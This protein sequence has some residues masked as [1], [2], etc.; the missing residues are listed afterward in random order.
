MYK[1]QLNLQSYI[2]IILVYNTS[3]KQLKFQFRQQKLFSLVFTK[4]AK[5]YSI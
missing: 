5:R 2:N 4:R 3:K 1:S